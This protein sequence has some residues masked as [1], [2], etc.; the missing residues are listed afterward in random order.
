MNDKELAAKL[1]VL[2]LTN[3]LSVRE[4]I[5]RFPKNSDNQ[6]IKAAY[7]AL[8]HYEAD[9]DMRSR[10]LEFQEEQ[11]EYLAL[12]AELLQNNKELPQNIINGYAGYNHE[13]EFSGYKIIKKFLKPLCKFLNIK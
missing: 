6:S 12:I 7:H 9:E 10:D 2:V 3:K 11:D 13:I 5:L 1:I 4:A 8:I